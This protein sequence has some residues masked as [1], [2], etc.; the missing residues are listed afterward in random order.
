MAE[1]RLSP[2]A[3]REIAETDWA[4]QESVQK[5]EQTARSVFTMLMVGQEETEENKTRARNYAVG[6][7]VSAYPRSARD[8]M[9]PRI[10]E[11]VAMAT[12]DERSQ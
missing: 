2:R 8:D 6:A 11:L 10:E 5:L 3:M 1:N 7:L 4:D 12:K 9:R